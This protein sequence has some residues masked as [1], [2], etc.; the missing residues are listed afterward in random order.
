MR[1]LVRAY[2]V[3][4]PADQATATINV[5]VQGRDRQAPSCVPALYVYGSGGGDAGRGMLL[6][7][8]GMELSHRPP[9]CRTQVRETVSPGSTLVTLRCAS[10]AGAE[11]SLS[12]ALEGPPGSRSRFRM[13]GSQLQVSRARPGEPLPGAQGPS[14]TFHQAGHSVAV[15]PG[16]TQPYGTL[17]LGRST[18]PWTTT[19]RP[20]LRWASS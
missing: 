11:G 1:L 3:L 20:W 16:D 12:Y 9:R 10:P 6:C 7:A 5:T 15:A 18:P 14:S 8:Q 13:E 2:N 19:R 17:C 4:Q